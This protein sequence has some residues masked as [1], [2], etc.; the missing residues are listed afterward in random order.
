MFPLSCLTLFTCV[1]V[2]DDHGLDDGDDRDPEIINF[3]EGFR[4][5][6]T[7]LGIFHMLS[8]LNPDNNPLT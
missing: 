8:Q 6:G 4:G 5:P 3:I 2:N 1:D 7:V